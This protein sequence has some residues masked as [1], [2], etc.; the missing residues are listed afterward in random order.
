MEVST[1]LSPSAIEGADEVALTL[2]GQTY[3]QPPFRYQGKCY[4]A[5]R[6]RYAAL[7]DDARSRLDPLLDATGCLPWLTG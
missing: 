7:P 2:N 5:L 6:A 4:S 1:G 3:R